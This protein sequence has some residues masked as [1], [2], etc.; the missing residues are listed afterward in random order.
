[1]RNPSL[2]QLIYHYRR[3]GYD[4]PQIKKHGE[5]FKMVISCPAGDWEVIT[6]STKKECI[7]NA[8]QWVKQNH[9]MVNKARARLVNEYL[10]VRK[11]NGTL[12]ANIRYHQNY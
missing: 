3:R 11:Q 5:Q 8:L 4:D 10:R 9:R 6:G 12:D 1:M 2:P 7:N